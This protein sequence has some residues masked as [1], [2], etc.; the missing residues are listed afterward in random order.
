MSMTLATILFGLF[1]LAKGVGIFFLNGEKSRLAG[2]KLLRS[3]RVDGV[4]MALA[5]AWFLWIVANLG[6]ADFGDYKVPLFVLFLAVAAGS[7]F[8]VKD[9]LGVRAA[10]ALFMM[11]SWHLLK[12]AFGH[13]EVPARLFMV[14]MV[15]AGLLVS[16]YFGAAPYRARDILEWFCKHRKISRVTGACFAAYGLWLCVVPVLFY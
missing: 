12:A 2:M 16:L 5:S 9:F 6:Q 15:Y 13:Y 14:S 7:W 1:L 8:Y 3:R 4:L 10:A 11:V